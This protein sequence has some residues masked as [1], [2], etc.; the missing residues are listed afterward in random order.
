MEHGGEIAQSLFK[1]YEYMNWR[2]NQANIRREIPAIE[3]VVTLM[4]DLRQ[5]WDE[6]IE[7]AQRE[8]GTPGATMSPPVP[9]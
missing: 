3:E 4:S 5:T 7:K 9:R 2:L 8:T 6:A 1:L